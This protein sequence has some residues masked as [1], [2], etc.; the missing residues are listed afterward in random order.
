L[1]IYPTLDIK[2]LTQH[3]SKMEKDARRVGVRLRG[4]SFKAT[5]S[6][7]ITDEELRRDAISLLQL[8]RY[9]LDQR[10]ERYEEYCG[11]SAKHPFG[12]RAGEIFD[13]GTRLGWEN[14]RTSALFDILIDEAYLV[15]HVQLVKDD[16]GT[17]KVARTFEP[18]GEIV[19]EMTRQY[20]DQWGLPYGF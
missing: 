11:C 15:T 10:I 8:I 2:K 20:I 6:P 9:V 19:S 16:D 3:I 12:L 4:P 7:F 1:V 13:L 5:E 14:V 17:Q 18:D